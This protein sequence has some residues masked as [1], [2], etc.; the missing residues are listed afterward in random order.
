M[1][2]VQRGCGLETSGGRGRTLHDSHLQIEGTLLLDELDLHQV[3]S[4]L[5]AA[6]RC[7]IYGLKEKSPNGSGACVLMVTWI[8][9][10]M[11]SPSV[12]NTLAERCKEKE[13]GGALTLEAAWGC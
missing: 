7:G 12:S 2:L 10:Q 11:L 3:L 9:T 5:S 6:S 1:T 4:S 13:L 8:Q